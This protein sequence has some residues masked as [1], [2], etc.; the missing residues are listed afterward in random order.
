MIRELSLDHQPRII[1]VTANA[2][3]AAAQRCLDAGM[4]DLLT[5]P[6]QREQ[7]FAKLGHA[8]DLM[9]GLA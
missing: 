3:D 6:Y 2:T 7:L 5:K 8:L 4:D 9:H 1:A